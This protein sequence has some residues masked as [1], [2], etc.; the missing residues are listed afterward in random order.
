VLK[1]ELLGNPGQHLAFQTKQK[2]EAENLQSLTELFA[3]SLKVIPA[4]RQ[5]GLFLNQIPAPNLLPHAPCP[6]P[7]ALCPLQHFKQILKYRYTD[8]I[9]I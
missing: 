7:C 9:V 4:S 5:A 6:M 3:S 1:Y 2:N 8:V